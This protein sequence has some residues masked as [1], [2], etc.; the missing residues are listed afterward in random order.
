MGTIDYVSNHDHWLKNRSPKVNVP[1]PGKEPLNV[2]E[3][4][5]GVAVLANAYE[6]V[7]GKPPKMGPGFFVGDANYLFEKG[8]K[9][10]F[11]VPENP[12]CGVHGTNEYVPVE[13]VIGATKIYAAMA[14]NWCELVG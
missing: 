7:L 13:H 3:K 12:D 6:Q 4:D 14:M 2:S 10:I 1:F 5:T 9:C 11:F 8:Q